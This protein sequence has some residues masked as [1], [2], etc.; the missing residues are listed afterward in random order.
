V[1]H[2]DLGQFKFGTFNV[3]SLDVHESRTY[4]LKIIKVTNDAEIAEFV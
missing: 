1:N 4:K 2:K 3:G